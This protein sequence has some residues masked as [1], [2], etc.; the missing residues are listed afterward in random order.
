MIDLKRSLG[1]KFGDIDALEVRIAEHTIYPWPNDSQGL[2]LV[3]H[4]FVTP[5]TNSLKDS[6]VT[7]EDGDLLVLC[8][9][10]KQWIGVAP[11][12]VPGATWNIH[13][14]YGSNVNGRAIIASAEMTIAGTHALSLATTGET[15]TA[16]GYSWSIWRNHGGIGTTN[17]FNVGN[18]IQPT[19]N[20]TTT[21]NNSAIVWCLSDSENPSGGASPQLP[22]VLGLTTTLL[23]YPTDGITAQIH[24]AHETIGEAGLKNVGR[25]SPMA[26]GHAYAA[27]EILP[28]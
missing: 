21:A 1:L 5:S 2:Y 16:W 11:S 17:G 27:I 7:V 4:G 19:L 28:A 23:D 14:T 9:T 18:A 6:S 3:D 20:I 25:I 13:A 12:T 26:D 10:G 24:A 22:I 15:S 8:I